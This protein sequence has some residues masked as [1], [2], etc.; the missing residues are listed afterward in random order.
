MIKSIAISAGILVMALT[1]CTVMRKVERMVPEIPDMMLIGKKAPAVDPADP[2]TLVPDLENDAAVFRVDVQG[3]PRRFVI[4]LYPNE[5]PMTVANFQHRVRSKHYEGMAIHRAIP[6]YLV[7]MGDPQSKDPT[8]RAAWG[9]GGFE[10][11][12]PAEIGLLHRLGAVGMAR[13]GDASNPERASSSSQFYVTL[14]DM[15]QFDGKYTIFGQV[16]QGYDSLQTI[17]TFPADENDNPYQRLEIRSAFL[18]S[19]RNYTPEGIESIHRKTRR[20]SV[21]EMP[22]PD[23]AGALKR[24][25]RRIW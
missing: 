11:T 18:D 3:Q 24:L 12:L 15:K 9:T 5:A 10:T 19:S 7:Q 4:Q 16:I 25:W 2:A 8:S 23:D 21:E 13:L 20:R 6:N 14:G 17:S 22:P 1:S